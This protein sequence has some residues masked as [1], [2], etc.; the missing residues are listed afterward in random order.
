[1]C[2]RDRYRLYVDGTTIGRDI[3]T[4]QTFD[5][6]AIS[7]L[8]TSYITGYC[9]CSRAGK[10]VGGGG[11]GC[12]EANGETCNACDWDH[13]L[14]DSKGTVPGTSIFTKFCLR[15][16]QTLDQLVEERYQAVFGKSSSTSSPTPSSPPATSSPGGATKKPA[17]SSPTSQTR[18]PVGTAGPG[19]S[20]NPPSTDGGDNTTGISSFMKVLG[21]IGVISMF[22][23]GGIYWV[24]TGM[25]RVRGSAT[26]GPIAFNSSDA[27]RSAYH[28]EHHNRDVFTL[29]DDDDDD[30]DDDPVSRARLTGDDNDDDDDEAVNPFDAGVRS[31]VEMKAV[32]KL[33]TGVA[34]TASE[35]NN[36]A[37]HHTTSVPI[38]ATSAPGVASLT[39]SQA[40]VGTAAPKT[41]GSSGHSTPVSY[42]HLTLPT[43]RIV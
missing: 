23:F 9:S 26:G 31:A 2:I 13:T 32:K 33:S 38:P 10:C 41:S 28:Q 37:H 29:G 43:K 35:H 4:T 30:V 40:S 17:T 6:S 20:S 39:P 11:C 5:D 14:S 19:P 27:T 24:Q 42:T 16:G 22:A 25:R 21:F 15:D 8:S 12:T 1:M 18:P 34:A 3:D 7:H 36:N